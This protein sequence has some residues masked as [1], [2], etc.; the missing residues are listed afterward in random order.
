LANLLARIGDDAGAERHRLLGL[1]HRP[2]TISRFVGAGRPIHIL[3]LGTSAAGN[4]PT[5]G[6]FDNRVFLLASV[7]VEHADEALPLPPHDIV[8]NAIGEA[9]LCGDQLARCA[10]IVARTSAP[11]INHPSTV[12]ATGRA[13]NAQRLRRLAGVVTAKTV[14]FSRLELAASGAQA[15]LANHGFTYPLLVRSPGYHTGDHFVKVDR[16]ADLA[17]AVAALPGDDLL[18]IEYLDIRDAADDFRKYRVIIV[19]GRLYPLHLAISRSWKVHYFSADMTNRPEHRAADAAF[20]NDMDAVLGSR[21]VAALE[22]VRAT[23]ALDYGGIDFAVAA[24]G[25]VIV[26]EA[27]ASMIVPAPEPAAIWDY[28]RGPVNRIRAA[29]HAMLVGRAA[30]FLSRKSGTAT[31]LK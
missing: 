11:V 24:S 21:V 27:N 13:A 3:G 20:L 12:A 1:R 31:P 19:D 25:D 22:R 10:A 6:Y 7:I 2:V 28:R 16:P 23:L 15:L 4:V 30:Q 18:V 8:F 29:V 9:D 26:F 14:L 5:Y 17:A